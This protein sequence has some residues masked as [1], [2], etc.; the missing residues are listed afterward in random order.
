MLVLLISVGLGLQLHAP[1]PQAVSASPVPVWHDIAADSA[2]GVDPQAPHAG[3]L[4]S[5]DRAA[6]QA[7]L[8]LA[9]REYSLDATQRTVILPLPLPDGTE[10]RFRVLES[11]IV[12]PQLAS[13]YPD[14]RTYT[15]QGIDTP[16]ATG[17]LDISPAGFHAIIL[18]DDEPIYIDPADHAAVPAVI[19]YRARDGQRDSVLPDTVLSAPEP[20]HPA[21]TGPH[22]GQP[23]APDGAL[24]TYRLA[25]AATGEYTTFHGGTVAR[26]LAAIVTAVNRINSIYER[27][28]AI[29]LILVANTDHLIFTDAGSDPYTN[30][31]PWWMLAQNQTTLTTIIGAANYDIGHVFGTAGGGIARLASVCSETTKARGATGLPRPTGDAFTIEYVAHELGHQFGAN[32]TFNGT[33]GVCA[34]ARV[35]TNAYEPGNGSTIMSYSGLCG[36][37]T[38]NL[39]H[40]SDTYFHT[41]SIAEIMTFTTTGGGQQ[42]R[43]SQLTGNSAPM[44]DAGP[45]L[46]IPAHTPFSLTGKGSDPDGDPLTY[47]WEQVDLGA[48]A[49]PHTDDGTRPII[50]SV[51]PSTNP[52]RHIPML[53]YTVLNIPNASELLPSTSRTLQFRLTGRDNHA[54]AGAVAM[55][56]TAITVAAA[57][58]PFRITAPNTPTVWL[59]TT[60]QSVTWDVAGTA[61]PPVA[62]A[63][64]TIGFSATSGFASPTILIPSTSNDG[65]AT[66]T[67]PDLPTTRGRIHISCATN[68][69]FDLSDADITIVTD[70][71]ATPTPTPS[72][73]PHTPTP[74]PITSPTPTSTIPAPHTPTPSLPPSPSPITSPTP[75]RITEPA[76]ATPPS[77]PGSATTL[78]LP[79]VS[80]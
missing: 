75:T 29:R 42:C 55:D 62:C 74:S 57:T 40:Q 16:T 32:H 7:V 76:T 30:D 5:I 78:Y 9:P 18:S 21:V 71:E 11:P 73:A 67:V 68:I 25:V 69:F 24:R 47:T 23:P 19:S 46:T 15:I 79:L 72:P 44:V 12:E 49:P 17:R 63:N 2:H 1:R 54:G 66:I 31:S 43:Q 77:G 35:A 50:R 80:R 53:L 58:G 38:L 36:A 10:A 51:K 37:D 45:D 22:P 6:V 39:P 34:G 65:Q 59:R 41:A 4:V 61:A 20:G 52:V 13:T 14:I 56:E 64:V 33:S 28:V 26:G 48:A 70:A 3:R 60:Q 8:D 27:D